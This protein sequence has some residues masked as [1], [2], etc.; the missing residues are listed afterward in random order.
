V[1]AGESDK[2]KKAYHT[3]LELAPGSTASGY[4]K[5]QLEKL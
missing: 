5:Q 4:V 3:Y 1:R 2:A